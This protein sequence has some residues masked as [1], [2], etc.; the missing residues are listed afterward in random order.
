MPKICKQTNCNN[1][2]IKVENHWSGDEY[3][4]E[5][6]TKI[7]QLHDVVRDEK[8]LNMQQFGNELGLIDKDQYWGR[9]PY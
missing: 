4:R 5:C 3:C 9:K 8:R 1:E 7:D 6:V 2:A